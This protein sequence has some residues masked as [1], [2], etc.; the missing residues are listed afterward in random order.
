MHS[1][2]LKNGA[3]R[4]KKRGGGEL[5]LANLWLLPMDMQIK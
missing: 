3:T 5:R 4:E 2:M 1:I